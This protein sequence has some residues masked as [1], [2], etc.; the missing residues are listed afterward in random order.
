MR[1]WLFSAL[2]AVSLV[3]SPAWSWPQW[4]GE[5]LFPEVT[6]VG[7]MKI[8][9]HAVAL[10]LGRSTP[11]PVGGIIEGAR[12]VQIAPDA[13]VL[14]RGGKQHLVPLSRDTSRHVG[15]PPPPVPRPQPVRR[16][17]PVPVPPAERRVIE[18]YVPVTPT[19]PYPI[20]NPPAGS[21]TA[22]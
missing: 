18:R 10:I 1:C 19:L 14:S 11:L 22:H 15:A 21:D 5:V 17:T 12:I 2:A 16:G 8:G 6:Y 9:N 4:G 7:M 20:S 3:T 13:L